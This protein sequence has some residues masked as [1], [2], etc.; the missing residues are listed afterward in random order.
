MKK[1]MADSTIWGGKKTNVSILI[2]ARDQV[3]THFTYSLAELIKTT[4][5]LGI[6]TFL[7]FEMST[8]LLTQRENLLRRALESNSEYVLW[9]D[10]DMMFP[11]TS[12]LRLLNHNKDVVGCNYMKRS[13]PLKPTAYTKNDDWDSWVPLDPKEGLVEAESVGLG[14]ILMKTKALK[15][16]SE[17]VFEFTYNSKSKDWLG[18]DFNFCKKLRKNNHTIYID[19]LLSSEIKHIGSY[20]FGYDK[21]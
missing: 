8:I 6:E 7:F 4:N 13:L 3:H 5:G 2:P 17:P 9:L 16:L 1:S 21:K 10:T 15:E 19:T 12:L 20:A 11:S 14:C 18:E